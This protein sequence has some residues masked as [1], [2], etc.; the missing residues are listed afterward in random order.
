MGNSGMTA[1]ETL[2]TRIPAK[3]LST[4][5]KVSSSLASTLDLSEILQISVETAASLLG[6]HTGA[7]YTLDEGILR[8]GAA[9]PPL[10]PGIPEELL[11]ARLE[12]HPHIE[13]AVLSKSAVY[14][15]DARAAP[16]SPAEKVVVD[17]RQ[18]VSILYFPL[19][20]KE[21]AIGAFIVGTIGAARHFEESEVDLCYI[22]SYQVSL[23]VANARLYQ[24]T[25]QAMSELSQAYDST[26][27]GWS[28]MLDMRDHITDEHTHRVADLTSEEHTSELQSPNTH[29][30]A[31][32]RLKKKRCFVAT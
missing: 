19:L 26:L 3:G 17:S 7:I 28:R 6:F 10:P 21:D 13:Q 8:L 30:Y 29:S 23:A 24:K 4:L 15:D 16:L 31:V 9:T 18:L 1:Y 14:L 22:L 12:D 27:Q 20:L 25:Q 5:L 11:R 32:L 2:T